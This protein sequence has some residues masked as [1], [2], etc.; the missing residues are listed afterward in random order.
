MRVAIALGVILLLAGPAVAGEKSTYTHQEYFEHYEGTT[1]C[2][3]CHQDEAE[4]FFHSQHYQ[5]QGEA[6]NIVNADGQKLGKMNTMNDFCTNP[7]SNWIGM[8]N[9]KEMSGRA[10]M[11]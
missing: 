6:P 3:G 2:L 4:T 8:P 7:M 10:K 9:P 1:T 5:W 11:R